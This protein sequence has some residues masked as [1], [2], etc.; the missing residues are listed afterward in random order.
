MTRALCDKERK[1]AWSKKF[2]AEVVLHM[3][4]I[5]ESIRTIYQRLLDFIQKPSLCS[6]VIPI[7]FHNSVVSCYY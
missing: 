5:N 3:E 2:D 6:I 4:Q 7:Q 1:S